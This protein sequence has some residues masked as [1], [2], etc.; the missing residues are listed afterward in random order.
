M[1][2]KRSRT[3]LDLGLFINDQYITVKQISRGGFGVVWQAYDFSLKNFVAIKEL[4]SE[5]SDAKFIEM[6]YR[7]A[8]IAKNII[9]D[10]I[11]RVEHFWK[12]S[13]GSYYILM[14]FVNGGDLKDLIKKCNEIQIKIPWE[15]SVLICIN[16]LRALDYANRVARDSITGKPYGI[17]YRDISP[18]NVLIS[19]DGNV[20][21]SDFGIAKTADEINGGIKQNIV[22]G[23]YSYMSPEQ[24]NGKADIDHRSDIFSIAVVFYEMLTGQHLYAGSNSEIKSHVLNTKFDINLLNGLSFPSEIGDVIAKAL[25]KN[26]DLRYERAIEMYRDLRKV[27]KGIE[28]EELAVDMSSFVSKV[29]EQE[30]NASIDVG[31]LVKLLDRQEIKTNNSIP[32]IICNDFIVG[33][34]SEFP[35]VLQPVLQVQNVQSQQSSSNDIVNQSLS[36]TYQNATQ[37]QPQKPQVEAKG[38]TV[39]EEV[40]D[41][42]INKLKN[43]KS[44]II[45]IIVSLVLAVLIFVGLD[46]FFIQITSFGKFVYSRIYPPDVVITTVPSGATVS[47]KTREGE[48]VL[49]NGNSNVPIPL[50][51]VKPQTYIITALKEGFK[52]VQ[53]VVRIEER[54]KSDKRRQEKIEIMFDFMLDINSEPQGADVYV[55]GNKFGITPCKLQLIAGD[56][57]VKFALAGYEIL[58][59]EAEEFKDGQCNID[60]SQSNKDDMFAGVDK[61]Y[62]ETE[63]KNVDGENVFSIKGYMYKVFSFSSEPQKM[64]VHIEGEEK[65]RGETP[66]TTNIKA[67]AYKIRMLDPEGRYSESLEEIV[68]SSDSPSELN[69]RMKKIISFRV[70]AKNSSEFFTA[71]LE[72]YGKEFEDI[73]EIHSNK[74]ITISLPVGKYKFIFSADYFEPYI[75]NDV[76]VEEISSV[77]A[78]MIYSKV[79]L[80]I[81]VVYV[82]EASKEVPINNAFIWIDNKIVGRTNKKGV[83]KDKVIRGAAI[84]GKIV[85]NNFI[86]QQFNIIVSTSSNVN[87]IIL[88]S[89]SMPSPV[90]KDATAIESINSFLLKVKDDKKNNEGEE[91]K[92]S[93]ALKETPKKNTSSN[94]SVREIVCPYCGYVNVIPAGKKLRFCVNCAK[95]LKY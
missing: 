62:W 57:T 15:F 1:G 9:Y 44:K 69:V 47:M 51:K 67:G 7:E 21:L 6:F 75:R 88:I 42:F 56:H 93:V 12:G 29:M 3:N 87:K 92:S 50:R 11:V 45:K 23:K 2:D 52:P 86:E 43:L 85:A 16:M 17:V 84:K 90:E 35:T 81:S 22:T 68:V 55:D 64:D 25:E 82:N 40:G 94:N 63:F 79:P 46:I 91:N 59:S 37:F 78:E 61:Q 60:F 13:N 76:N 8:L 10:N 71:R 14:D 89:K 27:L 39:F 20:K 58:G 95:P 28:T 19:F 33:E 32:K 65:P 34:S 4:L 38:K 72:I 26:R 36:N 49:Q 66:L 83:W 5:F 74:P 73:K 53:R 77:N 30:L 24:I 18:E 31:N 41:W 80:I 54:G 70:K 48:V